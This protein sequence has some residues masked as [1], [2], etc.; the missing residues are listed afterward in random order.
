MRRGAH[1]AVGT[2]G[3]LAFLASGL[4]MHFEYGHLR[5]FD[6]ATRLSF[7]S[8]HIYLLF[9]ALVNV[10]IAPSIRSSTGRAS[11]TMALIGSLLVLAGPPCLGVAFI[12]EPLDVSL[13]RDVTRAGVIICAVG[14]MLLTASHWLSRAPTAKQGAT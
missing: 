4:Q 1:W 7:R 10:A 12:K 9:A 11:R 6:R 14:V 5:G 2:L 3:V 13:D 8:I